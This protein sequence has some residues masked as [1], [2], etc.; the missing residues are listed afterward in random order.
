MPT[1]F[2]RE[3]G[4][5]RKRYRKLSCLVVFECLLSQNGLVMRR[6][7]DQESFLY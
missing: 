7:D 4:N 1:D 5:M 2:A 6:V 3:D